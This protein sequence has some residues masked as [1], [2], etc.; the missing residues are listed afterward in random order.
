MVYVKVAHEWI[1]LKLY[2]KFNKIVKVTISIFF[3]Y[4]PISHVYRVL[5][6]RACIIKKTVKIAIYNITIENPL[7][8]LSS[9]YLS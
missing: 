4:V 9:S 5:R 2:S 6:K 1:I 7:I 3:I 8:L